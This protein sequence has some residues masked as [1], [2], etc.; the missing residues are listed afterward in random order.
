MLF[1]LLAFSIRRVQGGFQRIVGEKL[2]NIA[3]DGH[4]VDGDGLGCRK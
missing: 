1:D 3:L 2:E 4:L